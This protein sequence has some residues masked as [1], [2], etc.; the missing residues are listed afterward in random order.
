VGRLAGALGER[1]GGLQ[2]RWTDPAAWAAAARPCTFGGCDE[3]GEC[4]GRETAL[5][6]A[7]PLAL[8]VVLAAWWR[9]RRI[10]AA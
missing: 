6:L 1:Q 4:D 5:A 3:L 8:L 9:R 7:A 2:G 10:A